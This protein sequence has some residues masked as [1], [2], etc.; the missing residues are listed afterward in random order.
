GATCPELF[1][2]HNAPFD[3]FG[4]TSNLTYILSKRAREAGVKVGR[5]R[6]TLHSLRHALAKR[7]LD[8]S[9]PI[10]DISRI[11]GHVNRRTTSMYLRMDVE[12]L[13][14]CP[15]DPEEVGA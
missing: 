13:A 11:L 1:V 14:T 7:L 5:D 6:R 4:D 9:V 2:R 3:A 10:D 8:Q 12:Q 15:L